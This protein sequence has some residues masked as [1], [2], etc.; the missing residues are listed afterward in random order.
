MVGTNNI[1]FFLFVVVFEALCSE[2]SLSNVAAVTEGCRQTQSN[3]RMS[4]W[5]IYLGNAAPK[6]VGDN[7]GAEGE[8]RQRKDASVLKGVQGGASSGTGMGNQTNQQCVVATHACVSKVRTKG[9]RERTDV[10]QSTAPA[11]EQD[12]SAHSEKGKEHPENVE[13]EK[14]KGI[15]TGYR[16]RRDIGTGWLV[17]NSDVEG[18]ACEQGTEQ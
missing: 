13:E 7:K 4:K 2:N 18:F 5:Q 11:G 3:V 6:E 17:E 9:P 8:R 10:R 14:A 1:R 15:Q 16:E 12:A